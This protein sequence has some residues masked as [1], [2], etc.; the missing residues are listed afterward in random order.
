MPKKKISKKRSFALSNMERTNIDESRLEE[1]KPREH[2]KD[3][4]KIAEAL[5]QC[6]VE[7]D[8]EAFIEILDAYLDVNKSRVVQK[9]KISRSTVKVALSKKGNPT[10]KTIAHIVHATMNK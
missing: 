7:N 6:L 4:K 9:T 10:L 8:T 5:F 1:L 2:F 3:R